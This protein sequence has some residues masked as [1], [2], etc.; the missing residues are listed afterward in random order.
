[1]KK[2]G[3]RHRCY[4]LLCILGCFNKKERVIMK[5]LTAGMLAFLL[6]LSLAACG[7]GSEPTDSVPPENGETAPEQAQQPE[8]AGQAEEPAQANGGSVICDGY[9][10]FFD[11]KGEFVDS[12]IDHGRNHEI[13]DVSH[14]LATINELRIFN[15]LLPLLYMGESVKTMGKFDENLETIMMQTGWADDAKIEYSEGAG[16][17]VKGTGTDGSAMEVRAI[18]D[19]DADSVRLEAYADGALELMFEYVKAPGGY[20]AQYHYIDIIGFDKATPIEGLC[21]YRIV[22]NGSNGSCARFDNVEAQPESI[23]ATIPDAAPFIEGATH[24]FTIT[25]GSFTGSLGGEAF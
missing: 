15:Y 22:F 25:D 6:V 1:M 19:S 4:A 23:F 20:A 3:H 5:R 12:V 8:Q 7:G 16:Y 14:T 21:T 10:A 2:I 17:V 9:Q 13:V 18:Y 11:A 24:W